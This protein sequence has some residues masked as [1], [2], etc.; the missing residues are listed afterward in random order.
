M[1]DSPTP[2]YATLGMNET[3]PDVLDGARGSHPVENVFIMI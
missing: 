1:A 2:R 3:K